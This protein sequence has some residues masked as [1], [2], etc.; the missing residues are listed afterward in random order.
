MMEFE[1][2]SSSK[3][4]NRCRKISFG[5]VS[6]L[7]SSRLGVSMLFGLFRGGDG[8][9]GGVMGQVLLRKDRSSG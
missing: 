3:K 1:D 2:G 9:D 5:C 4:A 8:V 7:V 6:V